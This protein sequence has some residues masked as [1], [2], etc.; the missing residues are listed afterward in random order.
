MH[1]VGR[2]AVA[3]AC[4]AALAGG[5]AA[6]SSAQP[7]PAQRHLAVTGYALG[8]LPS[9][10]VRREAHALSAIG[11]AGVSI[12][13]DGTQVGHPSDDLDRLL[14]AAHASGLSASLLVSNWSNRLGRFDRRALGRLLR[15][16]DNRRAVAAGLARIVRRDG[17]DGVTVDLESLKPSW[18]PGLAGFVARL[19]FALPAHASI[20]IDVSA[21]TRYRSRGYDL[22]AIA[23]SVDRVALMAYDEHGPG[24]SGPGP[25]GALPWQ[26]RCLDAALRLV[27]ARQVDLGVAG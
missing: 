27:P 19:R 22:R 5:E 1:R 15:S 13:R 21:T 26:R 18:A 20:D 10:V 23:R 4:V 17:W 9:S 7:R 12:H 24:W 6:P 11:V 2:A 16:G 14:R 3:V 25:V 8:S